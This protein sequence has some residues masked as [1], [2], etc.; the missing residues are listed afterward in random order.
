M[1]QETLHTLPEL[2]LGTQDSDASSA[3]MAA[4]DLSVLGTLGEGGM[5]VVRLANQLSLDREVAIKTTR[6]DIDDVGARALLAEAYVTGYLEH[7]NIIPIYNVGRTEQGAPLIVMKRVEGLSWLELLQRPERVAAEDLAEHVD[8]LIQVANAVRFAHSRGIIHRDIKPDN[9]MIGHFDEVYLLDW[10]I[11]VSLNEER[12]LLPGRAD[13]SGMS[14]TPQYMAPE[15][16]VQ[17]VEGLDERTDVYLLGAT[18][19]H[20]LTGRPRHRGDRLL[21]VLF[22]AHQSV[23]YEYASEVPVELAEIANRAC[24]RDKDK[25]FASVEAFRDALQDFLQHRDSV[26][27][28]QSAEAKLVELEELLASESPDV[29]AVHDTYGECRFGF[30]QALR[31]WP[32]NEQATHGLQRCLEAMANY[33]LEQGSLDAARSCIAEFPEARPALAE[34]A[35][36][37]ARRLDADGEELERLKRLEHSL[38]LQE[39]SSTRSLLAIILGLLWT[40]TSLY[41][42]IRLDAGEISVAEDHYNHMFAGFRNVVIVLA[43]IFA[44]RKRLFINRVNRRV[45]YLLVTMVVAVSASRW[46]VWIVGEGVVVGRAADSLIYT[47]TMIAVG[48]MSDLRL[49]LLAVFYFAAALTGVLW[50]EWQLYANTFATALTLGGLAWI[51]RPSRSNKKLSL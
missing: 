2:R 37:L 6:E 49:C 46:S 11:A 28:S 42:S 18:L 8:I 16:T 14:G 35:D 20:V 9:V 13:A 15:M 32:E 25:R 40:A 29:L 44:F 26:V 19:H 7:P 4:P 51:W 34:R 3:D 38:D 43:C 5:G 50:P 22:S 41:A 1:R 48:L 47:V 33:H 10:G 45:I 12:P 31:M 39:S 27:L 23:P 17:D 24:R 30:F 21:E 36:E